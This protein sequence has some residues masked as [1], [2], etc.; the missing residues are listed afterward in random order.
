MGRMTFN[1]VTGTFEDSGSTVLPQP[2]PQQKPVIQSNPSDKKVS[3]DEAAQKVS[4]PNVDMN[5]GIVQ[6]H[7]LSDLKI[8]QIIDRDTG[9]VMAY[10]S[11]YALDFSFNQQRLNSVKKIEK[12]LSGIEKLFRSIIM[13]KVIDKS[14]KKQ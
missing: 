8:Y 9:E 7:E 13:D 3:L 5:E 12:C 14:L 10:I 11:G 1:P 2:E 6:F 4:A